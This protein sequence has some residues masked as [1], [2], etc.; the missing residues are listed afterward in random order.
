MDDA[1]LQI[2][3]TICGISSFVIG[4]MV[5]SFLNVCDHRLPLGLSVVKPRSRCPNCE[6]PIAAYDNIP[7]LSWLILGA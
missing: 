4:A 6:T 7:I 5:G 2:L 3:T 1:T